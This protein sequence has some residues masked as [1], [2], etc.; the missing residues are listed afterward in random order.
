MRPA[1]VAL[2]HL[3]RR[4][5]KALV[6]LLGLAVGAGTVVGT[7]AIAW[8]MQREVREELRS[9]GIRVLISPVRQEWDFT[10]AGIPVGGGLSYQMGDLPP[11]SV[12]RVA[13]MKGLDTVAPKLLELTAG[14]GGEEVLAI[15]VDWRSEGKLRSY[16][17]VRGSYPDR[18]QEILLGS[19][20]AELWGA[21]PG[22]AVPLVGRQYLVAGVLEETGQEEDGLAFLSLEELRR[23][24]GRPQGLSFVEVRAPGEDPH[25]ARWREQL[26]QV[27]PEAEV[28]LVRNV[29]EMRLGLLERMRA[30]VPVVTVVA[31]VAAALL[32]AAT[33]LSAVRERTREVGVLRSLGYRQAHVQKVFLTEVLVL[34]TG[35]ALAGYGMGIA[36]ARLLL[37][38]LER[39]PLPV[40][41]YPHLALIV[42]LGSA[43]VGVLAAYFPA[44]HGARLEPITALRFF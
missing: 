40:G 32:V 11:D 12:A 9:T 6:L 22:E 3:R 5:A 7:L 27:F 39:A 10:Y 36:A 42:T 23:R 19:H 24:V 34:S 29:E 44:R 20:L 38:L 18:D 37:P 31:V 43:A 15:G 28:T 1:S 33:E 14:P 13:K 41:W 35:A 4:P 16:W 21:E 8:T 2:Y 25:P 17:R 26:A 30:L